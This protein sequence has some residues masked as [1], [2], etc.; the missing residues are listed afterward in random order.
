MTI[1][2]GFR[3]GF[4]VAAA[5]TLL[6]GGAARAQEMDAPETSARAQVPQGAIVQPLD[7]GPGAELRRNL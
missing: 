4:L 6:T 1:S 2:A 5:G 3:R 7:T